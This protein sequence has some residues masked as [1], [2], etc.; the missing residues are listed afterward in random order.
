MRSLPPRLL[1]LLPLVG[2]CA[3]N[4][5]S[6]DAGP[7]PPGPARAD[8]DLPGAVELMNFMIL[9]PGVAGAGQPAVEDFS[10]LAK[11]GYSTVINLRKPGEAFP[12]DEAAR[13]A[14]AGLVYAALPMRVADFGIEEAAALH[15]ILEAAPE[16]SVLIHC[17]SGNRVGALWGMYLG[18][19][20]GLSPEDAVEAGQ[21][22]GMHSPELADRIRMSLRG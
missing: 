22:A 15:K 9:G 2:A 13:A 3:S 19:R 12:E 18:L 5:G 11:Q 17:G 6:L 8:A 14:A 20:D 4:P 7:P 1:L 21:R 10:E 16:G